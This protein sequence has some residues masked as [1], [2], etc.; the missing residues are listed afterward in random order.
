MIFFNPQ[1]KIKRIRLKGADYT[2]LKKLKY[3]LAMG[4]CETCGK[5]VKLK[6]KGEFNSLTC[7]H[8]SHLKHGS[9]KEDTVEGTKI[10]CPECHDGKHR[11]LKGYG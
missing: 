1:P 2:K 4:L 3:K 9:Q 7:A 5:P 6:I 10:E 11:A 8:L